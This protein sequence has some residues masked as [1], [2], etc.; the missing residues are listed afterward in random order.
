MWCG[1]WKRLPIRTD[2]VQAPRPRGELHLPTVHRPGLATGLS[3]GGPRPAVTL[4]RC[5]P[6]RGSRASQPGRRRSDQAVGRVAA[7]VTGVSGASGRPRCGGAQ[8]RAQADRSPHFGML[9][10]NC[11]SLFGEDSRQ[12]LLWFTPRA[13]TDTAEKL[14]L[15]IVVGTQVMRTEASDEPI[16]EVRGSTARAMDEPGQSPPSSAASPTSYRPTACSRTAS[17]CPGF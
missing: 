7:A 14:T 4:V 17:E 12:R 9:D 16:E 11:F 15:L 8:R 1:S 2:A 6:A 10:L 5:R 13:G 3:A